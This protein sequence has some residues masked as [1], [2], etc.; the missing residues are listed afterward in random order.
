MGWALGVGCD[1]MYTH[2][3]MGSMR[4]LAG[5]ALLI[6]AAESEGGRAFILGCIA[7]K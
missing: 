2:N 7:S 6:T 4:L 1:A 3:L 5:G